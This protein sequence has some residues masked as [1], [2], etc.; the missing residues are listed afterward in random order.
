[1]ASGVPQPLEQKD[2]LRA[3]KKVK[4]SCKEWFSSARNYAMYANDGGI[5]DEILDYLK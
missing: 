4:P 5:Y 3:A 2:L 1:M